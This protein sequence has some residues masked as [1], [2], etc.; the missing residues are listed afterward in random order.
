MP[1]PNH[2]TPAEAPSGTD[3][4]LITGQL[5]LAAEPEPGARVLE[6]LQSVGAD[7]ATVP[8]FQALEASLRA[9]SDIAHLGLRGRSSPTSTGGEHDD[10]L[11][12]S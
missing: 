6:G 8:G 11:R 9:A 4:L 7:V 12:A 3:R 2:L 1:K 5:D 10:P